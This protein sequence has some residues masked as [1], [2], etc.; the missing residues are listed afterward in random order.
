MPADA[1]MDQPSEQIQ[2]VEVV[3]EPFNWL[4]W[5]SGLLALIAVA[6]G[7]AAYV[8]WKRQL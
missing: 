4:A 2:T 1:P 8:S 3:P 7:A 5:L 6:S